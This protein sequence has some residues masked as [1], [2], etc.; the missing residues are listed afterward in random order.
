MRPSRLILCFLL[1]AFGWTAAS[2]GARWSALYLWPALP[3]RVTGLIAQVFYFPVGWLVWTGLDLLR[4]SAWVRLNFDQSEF[5]TR[6][7]AA[8]LNG[9]F[10]A[11]VICWWLDRRSRRQASTNADEAA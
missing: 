7:G 5:W 11:A 10:W 9:L 4:D 8:I 1:I 3:L 2:L 6:Y